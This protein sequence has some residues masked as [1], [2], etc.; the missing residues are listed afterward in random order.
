MSIFS[1]AAELDKNIVHSAIEGFVSLSH[2]LS[3]VFLAAINIGLI[4]ILFTVEAPVVLVMS[5]N[6][7]KSRKR[8]KSSPIAPLVRSSIFCPNSV[9]LR[10]DT[11]WVSHVQ[12]S[13]RRT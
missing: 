5:F 9:A 10:F 8:W 11:R 12:C 6:M 1:S 3:E 2:C 7:Y 4:Q 13:Y